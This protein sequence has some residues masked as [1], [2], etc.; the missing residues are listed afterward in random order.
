M[1][2]P[3]LFKVFLSSPG[4]VPQE[5]DDAEAV[6]HE[7]NASNEF[8]HHYILKLYRWDDKSVVLPMPVTDIPQ[9]SVDVYMLR[10]SACDLVIVLFWSRMGSPLIMDKREYLSGTHYEYSEALQGYQQRGKPTV[11]L[12]RCAEEPS[13]KLTDPKRDDKIKQFDHVTQFFK[14]FQDSE[15]RYTGGVNQYVS[16]ADFKELFKEQLLTYLRHRR[17]RGSQPSA[18]VVPSTPRFTGVPYRGL[19]ALDEGDTPI[20]FGR[21]AE[22]LELLSRVDKQRLVFVL[23]ASGSGKSSLV[24]AGVLPRLRERGWKLVRCVPGDDPFYA[25]A[26]ALVKLPE[27]GVPLIDALPAARKLAN[28]LRESPANLVEQIA[29]TLPGRHVLLFIDQ[30]EEIFTLADKNP[31]LPPGASAAFMQAIRQASAQVVTLL[32]MR[33]D[34][35]GAALP[36]FDELKQSAYGLTRPSP[37]ALYEMITR[38]AELAGLK[39]DDGLAAQIVD[40]AGSESG[41]LALISYVLESLYLRATAHGDGRLTRHDY[42]VELKG[43]RGAINTLAERAYSELPFDEAAR[44]KALQTVFRELIA[45]TEEDGQLIPT[46]RRAPLTSFK[47]NSNEMRLIETFARARLLVTNSP[48]LGPA[49]KGDGIEAR[50][51]VEVA[52]E[53]ILRH[54]DALANWIGRVKG[55]L[56]LFRQYERDA[57]TWAERGRDTPPPTHEALVYFERA[58]ASLGYVRDDLPEPLL[59]YTEPEAVRKLRELAALPLTAEAHGAR[60]DIGDRL[61]V[62]GDPRPG[63]G[64]KEGVPDILWLP[65]S[66]GGEI[67]IEEHSFVVQPFYMAQYLVTFAQYQA[68]DKAEDGWNNPAWWADMPQDYQ[69]QQLADQ[70]TQAPNNPRDSVSWYQSVAFARWLNNRLRGFEQRDPSGTVLRVGDNAEIRLPTEWEWQW[71]AQGGAEQRDYP[72][73]PWQSGYANTDEAGL[74]RAIAV[75]MYPQ[76]AAE[77]G[78][79][80]MA[81]NL[82]EWCLNDHENPQVIDGYSNEKYKV[83]RGGSF[84]GYQGF[85]A[86]SFRNDGDPTFDHYDVGFRL[87]LGAPIASLTSE[88]LASESQKLLRA[89]RASKGGVGGIP[90]QNSPRQR[91]QLW[92]FLRRRK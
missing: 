11:W 24:A 85:A 2:D 37:F 9:Q 83:L 7:I 16:H 4:D 27:M 61:A 81:G 64:V 13:I 45:L 88:S 6:I 63:V 70:R 66:P 92:D 76:G 36:Y 10:P 5:R 82:Y 72:W 52:H 57:K 33:A 79:L 50:A 48:S 39:L 34:F 73:G 29:L 89:Q 43:V 49:H 60:R 75:G 56:A 51:E 42:E 67:K 84:V 59:S 40:D 58:L 20:F 3:V 55:D 19:T 23:G 53:A 44:E 90:P 47:A 87:V 46:R 69:Q 12:Y 28:T 22:T 30:F 35:Y 1:P 25:L 32:T 54:W 74:G 80:D 41:A 21:E 17:D 62:I 38:P 14:Q 91:S 78:A 77:C 15:G 31:D 8:S 68:F 65:V 26:L 86:V 71:A 18:P